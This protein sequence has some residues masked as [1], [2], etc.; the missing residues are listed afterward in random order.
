MKISPRGHE[1]GVMRMRDQ[2]VR[3]DLNI[4][5]VLEWM[6]TF[7]SVETLFSCEGQDDPKFHPYVLFHSNNDDLSKLLSKLSITLIPKKHYL[8]Y[9]HVGVDAPEWLD[10]KLRYR[11]QFE[12]VSY[13]VAF[14]AYLRTGHIVLPNSY[15]EPRIKQQ[16][17][18]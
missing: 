16:S 4:I 6:Y 18:G 8:L 5:P 14:I 12:D 3:V 2:L 17:N 1:T 13:R 11:L 15:I 7:S 9:G 10:G